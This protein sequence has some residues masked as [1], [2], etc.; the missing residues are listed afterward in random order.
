MR[1]NELIEKSKKLI[2]NF[3]DRLDPKPLNEIVDLIQ[4]HD[5]LIFVSGVGKSGMIAQKIAVT[6]TSTGTR[7]FYIS[8]TDSMHGDFG[9]I[10]KGDVVFLLSKSGES[11][12]VI[13]MMP[14]LRNKEAIVVA[15]VSDPNS[16]LSKGA[17]KVIILPFEEELCPHNLAPT[18][19]TTGQLLFGDILAIA[20]ME[21]K[22]FSKDQFALNHP[23][24]RLGKRLTMKVKDIMLQGGNVPLC[25][26]HEKLIDILIEY[27]NKKAGCMLVTDQ[28]RELL[29]IFT[30]GDLRR[31]L[32]KHG[33]DVLHLKMEELMICSP[34]KIDGEMMAYDAMRYMEG[35][36]KSPIMVLPVVEQGNRVIGLVK[37]HDI[38][39]SGV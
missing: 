13:A 31:A 30:D 9:Q 37:L 1:V 33:S 34:K 15:V 38:I 35:D 25:Q 27:S 10:S 24:G 26:G 22:A 14:Y 11:D 2:N 3:L 17:D 32:Q 29:G 23:A 4:S 19:S 36:Q 5:G 7:A 21:K 6:L 16:R 28:N 8:P 39:Q 12:E 20:L 18:M